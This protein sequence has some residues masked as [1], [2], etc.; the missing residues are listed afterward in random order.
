MISRRAVARWLAVLLVLAACARPEAGRDVRRVT[1]VDFSDWHGQLEPVMVTV[2]EARRP[3]GGA[4][5]L[6]F[7]WSPISTS[8]PRMA[9]AT[10]PR[11][12]SGVPSPAR[13]VATM[14][15]ST[16]TTCAPSRRSVWAWAVMT[17]AGGRCPT[18]RRSPP[19]PAST[20]R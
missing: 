6:K 20:R 10:S 7:V 18:G 15:A 12:P 9:R 1:I 16:I 3:L 19:M 14:W 11:I 13:A 17:G 2:G 8:T 4:A 5:V